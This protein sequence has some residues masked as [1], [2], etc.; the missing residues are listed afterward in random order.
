MK[1]FNRTPTLQVDG[2]VTIGSRDFVKGVWRS[3]L[4]IRGQI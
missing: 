1:V 4:L 2:G 3:I